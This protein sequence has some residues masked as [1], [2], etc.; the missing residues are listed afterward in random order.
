MRRAKSLGGLTGFAIVYGTSYLH[1]ADPVSACERALAGG[2]GGY[3]VCWFS[4]VWSWRAM[5]RAEAR[6]LVETTRR[7]VVQ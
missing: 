2:I 6:R 1:G 4:A 3:M 7:Q 5:L